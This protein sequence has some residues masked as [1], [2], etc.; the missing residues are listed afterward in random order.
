M[1]VLLLRKAHEFLCVFWLFHTILVHN[2][3]FQIALKFDTRT[4]SVG[5]SSNK[6]LFSKTQ[7]LWI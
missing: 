4:L 1:E 5:E 3:S 7:L 2:S 6:Y